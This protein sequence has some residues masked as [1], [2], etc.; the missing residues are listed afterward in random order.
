MGNRLI[1][2]LLSGSAQNRAYARSYR[3]ALK[4][5]RFPLSALQPP[6][7][8]GE[9][10]PSQRAPSL[11]GLVTLPAERKLPPEVP[12]GGR[13]LGRVGAPGANCRLIR[14]CNFTRRHYRV[15]A[16]AR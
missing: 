8:F 4:A 14:V 1:V 5:G 12:A 15:G 13:S 6:T 16:C 10:F 9:R 2:W 3:N 7:R 11:S